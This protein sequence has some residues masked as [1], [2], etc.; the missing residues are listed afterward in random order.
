MPGQLKTISVRNFRCLKD[1]VVNARPINILFGPNGIGKSSFLDAIWFVRDCAIRGTETFMQT[2]Y[3]VCLTQPAH[4]SKAEKQ[5]G[6]EG[7]CGNKGGKGEDVH[8][9]LLTP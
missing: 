4:D 2:P 3:S 7:Q 9:M 8:N 6:K 5:D 1:V